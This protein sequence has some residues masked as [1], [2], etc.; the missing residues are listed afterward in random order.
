M[1]S[2]N[3]YLES[4]D[5][6]PTWINYSE[7]PFP[8]LEDTELLLFYDTPTI[9]PYNSIYTRHIELKRKILEYRAKY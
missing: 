2:G 3:T 6:T 1:T 9:T 7:R 5:S 4:G 8:L